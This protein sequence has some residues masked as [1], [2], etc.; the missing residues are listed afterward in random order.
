M[1]RRLSDEVLRHLEDTW[2]QATLGITVH[3]ARSQPASESQRTAAVNACLGALPL[4]IDDLQEAREDGRRWLQRAERN[5]DRIA[6]LTRE[7][8]ELR[9]QLPPQQQG[10]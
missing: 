9:Q 1:T 7:L 4:V 6:E 8:E 2:L 10:E 3:G 5:E